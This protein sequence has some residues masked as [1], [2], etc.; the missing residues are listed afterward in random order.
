[1]RAL[2]VGSVVLNVVLLAVVALKVRVAGVK[3]VLERLGLREPARRDFAALARARF[4]AVP[5][6]A[7][8]FVGD[9]QVELAPLLD[10]LELPYRNRGLSGARIADVASWLDG[11][12]A[13]APRHLV[14]MVGSN[15]VYFGVPLDQ[16]LAA[17][18]GL[19]AQLAGAGCPVTVL[20]VPPLVGREAAAARLNDGLAALAGEHGLAWID[21][22]PALA[23][24][25]WS[26]DTLHLNAAAYRAISP[27]I[28]TAALP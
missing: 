8:C 28:A 14:L 13:E 25:A 22:T 23:G 19:F 17:A 24:L 20:S 27:L 10:M 9:S 4:P 6:H 7:T 26:D 1:M 2:R 18:A 21:L 15:D 3:Q 5:T 12:L 11:V 16:S